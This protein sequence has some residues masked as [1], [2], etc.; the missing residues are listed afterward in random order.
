M[1]TSFYSG[2]AKI[3]QF[4][5]RVRPTSEGRREFPDAGGN[6]LVLN[7]APLR[8]AMT[9]CGS[10]WYHEAAIAEAEQTNKN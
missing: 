2:S 8:V 5:T 1:T 4:P 7:P 10:A 9:A 6:L 3:Y